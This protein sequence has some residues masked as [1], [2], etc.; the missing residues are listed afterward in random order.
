MN[1]FK[2]MTIKTDELFVMV[3]KC[4]PECYKTYLQTN[5]WNIFF[6]LKIV[7]TI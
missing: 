6:K 1:I 2:G 7:Y 4:I 5:F 3:K